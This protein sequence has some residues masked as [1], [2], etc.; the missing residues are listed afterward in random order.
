M[1]S[2]D[3]LTVS[4]HHAMDKETLDE[5]TEAQG[6]ASCNMYGGHAVSSTQK[7]RDFPIMDPVSPGLTECSRRSWP[8]LSCSVR[9]L[10]L[11]FMQA[12]GQVVPEAEKGGLTIQVSMQLEA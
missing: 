9:S 7:S 12:P 11:L 6:K 4:H 3:R 2:P 8:T 5:E 1:I 10:V